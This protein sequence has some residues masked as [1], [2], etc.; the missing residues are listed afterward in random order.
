[1]PYLRGKVTSYFRISMKGKGIIIASNCRL[2]IIIIA[3]AL[4]SVL[5]SIR[6]YH[7]QITQHEYWSAMARGQQ[8][9]Y[10]PIVG[11]RGEIYVT[12][13]NGALYTV[14]TTRNL[15]NVCVAKDEFSNEGEEVKKESIRKLSEIISIDPLVIESKVQSTISMCEPIKSQLSVLESEEILKSDID[16]VYLKK[17]TSRYYPYQSFLAHVIG[18]VGGSGS[19]QYGVE[20]YYEEKLKGQYGFE[21]GKRGPRISIISKSVKKGENITLT[22]DYNIQRKA[23]ELLINTVKEL[24]SSSGMIIV[25]DPQTGKIFALA[26]YPAFDPNNYSKEKDFSIF[27]NNAI[28]KTYEP[29]STFKPITMAAALDTNSVAPDTKY[30]DLGILKI[31]GSTIK[32]YGQRI[33]GEQTMTGV[34]EKSINTG[35]VFAERQAGNEKFVEYIRRF[36]FLETTKIDL[37]GEVY[38]KNTSLFSGREIN[39]TT[40]A[41]GQGVEVTPIQMV[42]AFSIIANRGFMVRPYINVEDKPE[43][44]SRPVISEKTAKDI[45]SMLVSVTENGYSK[46]AQIS[47]YFVAGKTGTAQVTWSALGVDKLGYSDQ[48]IQSFIGF[49]PAYDPKFLIM[50]RLDNPESKTAEYSAI[51]AYKEMAR[52]IIDYLQIPPDH[53]TP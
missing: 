5:L 28:Q 18:F 15:N 23:E 6:L 41:F 34:L 36:G 29:G 10:N 43:I 4:F 17:Q 46:A 2:N 31:G 21:E 33:Y 27:Q 16:G 12:D 25:I 42:R 38:S 37:Q 52:Y 26:N 1:M 50:I 7:L 48:T 40:A 35:A 9:F 44:L 49:L 20:G 51:P 22:I 19:G 30:V 45:V 3:I 14:A 11:E 53:K 13:K 24:K 47:G 39:Y 8:F 32:N